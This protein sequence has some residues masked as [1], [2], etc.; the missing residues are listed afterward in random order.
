MKNNFV[1]K[2]S[3]KINRAAVHRDKTKYTRKIKYKGPEKDL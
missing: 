3:R 2:H 1:A